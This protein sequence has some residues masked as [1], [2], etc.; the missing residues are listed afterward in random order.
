MES[1]ENPERTD[2]DS[3]RIW[4]EPLESGKI[5]AGFRQEP[6]VSGKAPEG[7][8]E[9]PAAKA[10]LRWNTKFVPSAILTYSM[11]IPAAAQ[12]SRILGMPEANDSMSPDL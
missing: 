11:P 1:G 9:G 4:Q 12:R 10:S 2:E 8:G 7:V 3:A 6:P 5:P